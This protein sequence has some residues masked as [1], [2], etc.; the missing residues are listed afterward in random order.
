VTLD[1][2]YTLTSSNIVNTFD[3]NVRL[4]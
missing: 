1:T 2:S 3:T 4:Y